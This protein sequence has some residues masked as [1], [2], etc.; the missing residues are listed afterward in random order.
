MFP[1]SA[2]YKHIIKEESNSPLYLIRQGTEILNYY[3][4]EIGYQA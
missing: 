2:G 3:Q 1:D 4:T